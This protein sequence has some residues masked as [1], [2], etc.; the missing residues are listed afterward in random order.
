M[1]AGGVTV[2]RGAVPLARRY[3]RTH[4]AGSPRPFWVGRRLQTNAASALGG[5]DARA[6]SKRR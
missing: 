6:A 1:G 5:G 2:A 3:G 4:S